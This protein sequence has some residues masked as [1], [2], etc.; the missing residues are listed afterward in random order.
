M[1]DH[2]LT[3]AKRFISN[4]YESMKTRIEKGRNVISE[5]GNLSIAWIRMLKESISSI[6]PVFCARRMLKEYTE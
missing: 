4:H 1:D 2:H 3:K 6:A 5:L